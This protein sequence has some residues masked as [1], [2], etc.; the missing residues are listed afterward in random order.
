LSDDFHQ[1]FSENERLKPTDDGRLYMD[2]GALD[3]EAGGHLPQVTV[4]FETWGVLNEAR[5]NAILV[6]HALSGD[7]HAIGWWDRIVGPGKALDT[8]KYFVVCTNCL[9]GCQGTTGPTS[10]GPDGKPY[11]THF[12][13]ITIGDMVEVQARL[14]RSLG[15]D[16]LLAVAGG[17]M[18]GMQVIEWTLRFP[19]RVRKAFITASTAAHSAM[20]IG[21][22]ETARQ[23]IMRDPAWNG[24]EYDGNGPRN[25][26]AVARMLGHLTYLSNSSFDAKFGRRL[27]GKESPAFTLGTEFEVESYLQYQGDKFTKRFDA[28]SLLYL[29]RACD[30][31]E[32]TGLQRAQAEFLIVSY[33]SDWIYPSSQS[34]TLHQMALDAGLKSTYIDLPLAYGHDCFL[35]DGDLQGGALKRFLEGTL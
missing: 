23:A 7:S 5:D 28:N 35:L 11:R 19:E 26:L 14:V 27:Q 15:I 9:G 12:P 34:A 24:G 13:V 8:E 1:L 2:V 25:G 22:N 33:V 31:Y 18:G 29:T 30:Y 10:V 32:V 6:C 17:S 20:Q 3:C 21:F 4:A 16:Q